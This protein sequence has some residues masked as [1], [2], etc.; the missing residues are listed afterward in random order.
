MYLPDCVAAHAI[1]EYSIPS[2]LSHHDFAYSWK[3]IVAIVVQHDVAH[4]QSHLNGKIHLSCSVATVISCNM[5][6]TSTLLF[7]VF[8]TM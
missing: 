3:V 7:T 6:C 8:R 4:L 1:G 2:L 5:E